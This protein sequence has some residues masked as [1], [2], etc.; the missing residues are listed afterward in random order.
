MECTAGGK[1]WACEGMEA[2]WVLQIECVRDER[3]RSLVMKFETVDLDGP[4][5]KIKSELLMS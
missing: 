4:I 1:D 5:K 2:N 3:V